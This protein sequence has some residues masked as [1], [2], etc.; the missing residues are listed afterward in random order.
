MGVEETPVVLTQ[1]R[2]QRFLL[3]FHPGARAVFTLSSRL[4]LCLPF[5]MGADASESVHAFLCESSILVCVCLWASRLWY[6]PL[7][8]RDLVQM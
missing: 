3:S 7:E 8:F 4:S 5:C 1:G 2:P 6:L